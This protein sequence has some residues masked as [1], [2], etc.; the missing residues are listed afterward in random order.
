MLEPI[1]EYC[2]TDTELPNLEKLRQDTEEPNAPNV[3]I[4]KLPVSTALPETLTLDPALT[5][6]RSDIDDPML[7]KDKTDMALPKR[8]KLRND[9]ELPR[10]NDAI[11]E[12]APD[13]RTMPAID[14]ELPKRVKLLT[15]HPDPS[16]V[17]SKADILLPSLA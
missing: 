15:E 10:C 5:K 2:N 14:N 9:I 6:A 12:Y 13:A 8:P 4:E 16:P 3:K 11:T 1:V 7:L 17:K